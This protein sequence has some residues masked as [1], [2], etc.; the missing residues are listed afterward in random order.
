MPQIF[1]VTDRHKT[2][3]RSLLSVL[4]KVVQAG[5]D[6]II[7]REKDL[8]PA[9]LYKLACQVQALCAGGNTKL[10]I[11]SS[12]ETALACGSNGVHLGFG[13]L[14]LEPA[15]KILSEKLIG[16][17]IHSPAEATAAQNSGADYVLAGHIFA[18]A[19]KPGQPG[20]GL[21]FVTQVSTTVTVPVIV[22]GGITAANAAAVIK[23]GAA[24]IAV[25][26]SVMHSE[27]IPQT[28]HSLRQAVT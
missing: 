13:S 10:L 7:L 4:E 23:A 14:P 15:R 6:A 9:E 24:G 26:S 8:P 12:V 25:L 22:I 19:S 16:I 2:N 5:A 18:T 3:G 11:N 1:V 27:D 20:R 28:I 17:S 21:E